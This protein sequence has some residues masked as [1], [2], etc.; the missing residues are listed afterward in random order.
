MLMT[1][2]I[3]TV[4]V[5]CHALRRRTVRPRLVQVVRSAVL[6]GLLAATAA[7]T[8]TAS[9][10]PPAE[11]EDR[12]QALAERFRPVIMIKQ[13]EEP[14]DTHGEQYLPTSVEV[15]LDNPEIALRQLGADD[16][17]V[18]WGPGAS[19]LHG[20]G[21][22]FFLDFPGSALD[23][24][25]I[26]ERDFEKYAEELEPTVYA[27][28]VQQPDE[29]DLV[30]VQYWI[31]WYYNDWNNKHE[32][33][34]EG[35]TL[36]FEASSIDEALAGEPVAVGY[37]QHEGGERADWDDTKLEREGDRPVVYSSAGSHASYFDSAFY[38]GRS[39]SEGFGCDETTDP[40][41]RVDPAV[42]VL[43]DSVDDPNDPLAWL[44]FEGRWGERQ[45]GPF[46]GPTG[47]TAKDRWLDPAPW[48]EELR[49]TSVVIPGDDSGV[50]GVVEVF[51]EVVE[52]G[53]G[54]LITAT[55]S[56]TV[57]LI[58]VLLLAALI[59]F[60][61]RR[62]DWTPVG[63]EPI[64]RRRRAGQIVRASLTTY[65]R[66]PHV[67][68][69]FGL[70]YIPAAVVTG[71]LVAIVG[72]LPIIST[73]LDLAGKA[74]GTS[75]VLAAL[76]GSIANLAAF[77]LICAVVAEYLDGPDRGFG[78][79]KS[80]VRSTWAHRRVLGGSYLRAF[81]I[82]FVLL[83]SFVGVPWGIRQMVRYQFMPQAVTYDDRSGADALARSSELVR[84]RWLH[85]GAFVAV[86]NGAIN[87]LAL[88]LALL[89]LVG[90]TGLPLWLFSG[91][92]ALVYGL[93]VPLAAI[94]MALLY[95][96]AVAAQEAE[97]A[98]PET[99]PAG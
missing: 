50:S 93:T 46:N 99:V 53:S 34:W 60:L 94:A 24:K 36:K 59:R 48:F 72:S 74:S 70:V 80:A 82:V 73:I 52:W 95:G 12:V 10:P 22:G 79:A 35:I 88:V 92:L 98:E 76:A 28:I 65:R 63:P 69:M 1:G 87:L 97:Q 7:G 5:V 85:T 14:C 71:L 31:Y 77:V 29:P 37:S 47:P 9:A 51:C 43:P 68:A 67:Y 55:T 83:A 26:Y 21:E 41:E 44:G 40:S 57:L 78:A 23:P 20:L 49:S 17:V 13:Q 96:D 81:A 66:A 64:V 75:I 2:V 61:V 27:H 11:P 42:V 16:P 32:S 39:A 62:T 86:I 4:L 19:D 38:L 56:P 84:G 58:V 6:G 33:D 45:N 8:I 18:M 25:C 89:L 91:L 15:V 3:A 54:L 90:V 30:F